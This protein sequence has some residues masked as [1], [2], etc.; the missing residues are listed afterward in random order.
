MEE[1]VGINQQLMKERI[2]KEYYQRVR[3]ILKTQL[4]AKNKILAINS[5]SIPVISYSFGI[6]NRLDGRGGL[7]SI[8]NS[9]EKTIFELNI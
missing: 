9:L 7:V 6:F 2:T 8:E 5:L 3:Q 4:N 1:T